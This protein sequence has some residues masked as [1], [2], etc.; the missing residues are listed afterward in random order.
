MKAIQIR[1]HQTKAIEA[2]KNA[3]YNKQQLI[4]IEMATGTGTSLILAKTVVMTKSPTAFGRNFANGGRIAKH[5][6]SLL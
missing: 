5:G 2:I 3:I 4:T 6:R 1:E